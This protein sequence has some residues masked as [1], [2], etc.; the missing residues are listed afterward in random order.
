[1]AGLY[2]HIPFCASRCIYCGFYSTLRLDQRNRYIGALEMEMKLRKAYADDIFSSSPL[3]TIYLGGGT[4]SQLDSDCLQDLFQ[5]IDRLYGTTFLE[6]VTMECNPDDLTPDYCKAISATPVNRISMGVQ[7]FNNE[8]LAFLHRRHRGD[9]I[10]RAID[11]LRNSG[12]GN[13]SIDLMF[14][15]PAQDLTSW[16]D[17]ISRALSLDVEHISAYS[18]T[19]EE[20]TRL[21]EMLRKCEVDETGEDDS[22]T[23][24]EML[25]EKLED[26]G[27]NHYE[28]SNFSKLSGNP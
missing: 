8:R 2:V 15:F 14:G 22:R 16:E 26:A 10:R 18:L 3:K 13:I 19:Y 25:V 24:Y 12:I 17:D 21:Y 7:T 20:G 28:I 6:E 9:D 27:Y 23:M 5:T 4:P 11:N 1:M